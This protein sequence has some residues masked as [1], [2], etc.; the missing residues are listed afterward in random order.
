ME[1]LPKVVSWSEGQRRVALNHSDMA[2]RQVE[3][4]GDDLR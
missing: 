4:L 3:P 1:K 2:H